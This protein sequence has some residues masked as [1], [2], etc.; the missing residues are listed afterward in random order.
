MLERSYQ[1]AD[2]P[3]IARTSLIADNAVAP[4]DAQW[5]SPLR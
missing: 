4:R 3:L 1:R 5:F 2:K